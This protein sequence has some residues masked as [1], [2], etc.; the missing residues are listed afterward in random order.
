M[1]RF[2]PFL[3]LDD[4]RGA[5]P[6]DYAAGFPWHPHRGIET[7]TYMI[8][9]ECE[10]GDSMGN[11]GVIGTGDVQWMTAGGG[12]VHQEMP[13]GDPTGEMGG[14]QLWAN[15]PAAD[16]MMEPRYRAIE[17]C[18]IPEVSEGSTTIRVVAGRIGDTSGPVRDV[19]I[20]PEYFDVR[21]AP[22][23]FW[24]HPT[25]HDH[26]VFVYVYEGAITVGN[27]ADAIR[28]PALSTALLDAGDAAAISTDEGAGLLFV[29]GMPLGEPI[30]WRGPIVMNTNDEL[31][32][33]FREY[34][35]GTFLDRARS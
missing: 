7:I 1:G 15:L 12:I 17:A 34:R 35:E 28:V 32:D 29:S 2:D 10:H 25:R 31:R 11:S 16:K 18:D 3:L 14:F 27:E 4:F 26:T 9:G 21:L 22:G 6:D 23:G 24:P 13:S 33:A 20:D 30:A 5:G 8:T 19:V